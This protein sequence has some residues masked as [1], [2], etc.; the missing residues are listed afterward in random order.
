MKKYGVILH[1]IGVYSVNTKNERIAKIQ[2]NVEDIVFSHPEVLQMHGF[3]LDEKEKI[4][5]FDIIIDFNAENR[6]MIYQ[7]IHD[8]IHARYK[9]HTVNI[10]LDVDTSD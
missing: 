3:Y 7:K 2:K 9:E 1:T 4:I 5:S 8:E 6:E 10:T